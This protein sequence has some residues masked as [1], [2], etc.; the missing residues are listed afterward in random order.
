MGTNSRKRAADEYSDP[1]LKKWRTDD[2][3]LPTQIVF[4]IPN[5]D[6]EVEGNLPQ[7]TRW[8][9]TVGNLNITPIFPV[10][11]TMLIARKPAAPSPNAIYLC[12]ISS[13]YL[14]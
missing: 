1:D 10:Y 9:A 14:I 7:P 4:D 13:G 12:T 2:E 8:K 3:R 11:N 5:G 6:T